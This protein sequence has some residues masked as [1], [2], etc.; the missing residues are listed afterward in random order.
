MTMGI[1]ATSREIG[2]LSGHPELSTTDEQLVWRAKR[3]DT[4]AFEELYR[5]HSGKIYGLCLRLAGNRTLA[6]D[7]AQDAFVRAWEKLEGFRGDAAFSSWLY[8]IATNVVLGAHRK[9]KRREAQLRQVDDENPFEQIADREEKPDLGIDLEQAIAELPDGART[10]FVLHD[11]EGMLHEEIARQ[12]GIAVGT[13]KAQ[14][15][16]AR[17]LLREKLE[18]EL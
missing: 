3:G 12:T 16:R 7:C 17:K 8:R 5:R 15:H 1:A 18:H 14:L 13:S 4:R 6:Q 2:V 9:R 11:V 10:V